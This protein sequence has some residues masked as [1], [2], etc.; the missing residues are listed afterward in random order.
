[1]PAL[2]MALGFVVLNTIAA[3]SYA[4]GDYAWA[5]VAGAVSLLLLAMAYMEA[6]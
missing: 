2:W 5:A 4:V 3:Y 1:M 6:R